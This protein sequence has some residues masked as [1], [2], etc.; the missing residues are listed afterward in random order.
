M[1]PSCLSLTC[2]NFHLGYCVVVTAVVAYA[3][4]FV[5]FAAKRES[6]YIIIE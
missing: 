1:L 6:D 4:G 5:V 2:V 3:V